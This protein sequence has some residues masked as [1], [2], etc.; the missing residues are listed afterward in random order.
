[1]TIVLIMTS[2]LWVALEIV[3]LVRDRVRG[4]GSAE[5]DR[6]SRL[7][8]FLLVV[9]AVLGAEVVAT[10]VDPDGALRLP[11][12]PGAVGYPIAG[13]VVMWLGLGLRLWAILV[14]GR[15]FR[16]TVEVDAGQRVVRHGPYRWVRHPSY[17]G[18]LLLAVGTGIAWDNWVSLALTLVLP[19]LALTWRI[20][21]EERVLVEVLGPPYESYRASTKRLVPGLW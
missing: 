15:A 8:N 16:T 21:V 10:A 17:T 7:I 20:A 2:Y 3:L 6:G 11:G 13:V 12:P 18:L 19:V 5:R 14:L 9:A 1:M 4:K